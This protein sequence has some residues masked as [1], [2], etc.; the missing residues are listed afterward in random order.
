M[1][2]KETA[3]N[4]NDIRKDHM[5]NKG[6]SA[7]IALEA[8]PP[9]QLIQEILE[10]LEKANHIRAEDLP[11]IHL[12]MDQVTTLMEEELAFTKRNDEDKVLT[13]TMINNYAKN[14][15]LPPPQKKKYSRDQILILI[16]IYYLKNVLVIRDIDKILSPIISEFYHSSTAFTFTDIYNEIIQA[17]ENAKNSWHQSILDTWESS[18]KGFEQAPREHQDELQLFSLICALS[19]DIYKKKLLLEKLIDQWPAP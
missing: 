16:L 19:F 1:G 17:E 11:N 9:T 18:S 4:S 13:K 3:S 10:H 12:Y 8:V 6:S 14:N 2:K 15:L 5:K 7:E